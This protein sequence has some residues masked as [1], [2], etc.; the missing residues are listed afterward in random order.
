MVER[1]TLR[2]V[3][4]LNELIMDMVS[5]PDFVLKSV[6]WGAVKGTHHSYKYVNI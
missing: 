1:I 4:N 6:D 2:R 3:K 5:T